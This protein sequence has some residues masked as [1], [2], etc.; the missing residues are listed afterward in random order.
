MTWLVCPKCKNGR[1]QQ[2]GKLIVCPEG[3]KFRLV[4]IKEVV[5]DAMQKKKGL[6]PKPKK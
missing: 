1:T 6:E 3:H 5:K 2:V 4:K